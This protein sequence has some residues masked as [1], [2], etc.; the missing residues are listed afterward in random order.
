MSTANKGNK[1]S[2]LID[3]GS[4][5]RVGSS[6]GR[7]MTVNEIN[8]N[9]VYSEE[10]KELNYKSAAKA[11]E[12]DEERNEEIKRVPSHAS[13]ENLMSYSDIN[14]LAKHDSLTGRT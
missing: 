8:S 12:L 9:Q 11:E 10:N 14:N 6:S 1:A 5:A 13:H 2:G 3:G 7:K 4:A